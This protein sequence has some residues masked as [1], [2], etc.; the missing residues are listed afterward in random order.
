M[1]FQIRLTFAVTPNLILEPCPRGFKGP[2]CGQKANKE[3]ETHMHQVQANSN[4]CLHCTESWSTS[5]SHLA[6]TMMDG[7]VWPQRL[8]WPNQINVRLTTVS[9]QLILEPRFLWPGFSEYKHLKICCIPG[10]VR[11]ECNCYKTDFWC[12]KMLKRVQGW[13]IRHEISSTSSASVVMPWLGRDYFG[14]F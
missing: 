2:T 8:N 3:E 12:K 1:C 11:P 13:H 14:F 4:W 9:F 7:P 10:T 5:H 6:F